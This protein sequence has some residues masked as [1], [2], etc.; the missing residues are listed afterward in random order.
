MTLRGK[1][2]R[3][4]GTSE[5]KATLCKALLKKGERMWGISWQEKW[6]QVKTFI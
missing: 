4:I 3:G 5:E 2:S 6:V 1:Q